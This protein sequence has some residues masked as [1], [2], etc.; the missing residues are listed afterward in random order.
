MIP[1]LDEIVAIINREPSQYDGGGEVIIASTSQ[2]AKDFSPLSA[3]LWNESLH[4]AL[5]FT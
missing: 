3:L 5:N 2:A 1:S 4:S